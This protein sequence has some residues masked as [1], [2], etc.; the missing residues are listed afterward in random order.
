MVFSAGETNAPG[1]S[2]LKVQMILPVDYGSELVPVPAIPDRTISRLIDRIAE[3]K[4]YNTVRRCPSCIVYSNHGAT[5]VIPVRAVA[6]TNIL[7]VPPKL[8]TKC[9]PMYQS[10][11]SN[12]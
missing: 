9:L 5:A 12:W 3:K 2:T 10:G 4:G 6:S 11:G 1:S 7:N 8:F